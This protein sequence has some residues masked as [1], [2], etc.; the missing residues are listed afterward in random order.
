LSEAAT[1]VV[2]NCIQEAIDE[3]FKIMIRPDHV[4]LQKKMILK[5]NSGVQ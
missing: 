3:N 4:V 2:K 1:S 5:A